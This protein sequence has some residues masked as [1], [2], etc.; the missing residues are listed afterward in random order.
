ML[1]R[2]DVF[3]NLCR[4]AVCRFS[5][6]THEGMMKV[7]AIAFEVV[8]AF[9]GLGLLI[10]GSL[11]ISLGGSFYYA[12]VGLAY[13]LASLLA[14]RG[15]RAGGILVAIVALLTIPWALWEAGADFWALFARLLSPIALAGFA[16]LFA[17]SLSA[18]ANR[19]LHYSGAV[20]AAVLF[21]SGMAFGF[22]PHGVIRPSADITP[23][24]QAKGDNTPSD[25]TSYG[26]T[27]AGLRYSPFDQINRGNV[28]KLDLAWTYRTG[29]GVGID[30]NT[31][32]QIGNTVYSCTPTNVIT[33]IDADTGK[34]RWTSDPKASAPIWQRCRGVGYY[35]VPQAAQTA[36]GICNE[37]LVQ[38][39]IDARIIELDVKTGAACPGFGN[40]GTVLL[41]QNMGEVK[42]GFYFQ[43]SAPLIARNLIIV[44]GWVADNQEVGEPSGVIRAF[45]V[46]TGELEWAWDLGNPAIT[47]MP[48]DGETYTRGTPNMWTTAAF[49]DRLGLI[50]AP[51]GNTTPDYYGANRPPF[52]DEYNSSIVALDVTTGR[53]RWKFQTVHHDIWDYDLP[54]QPALIDLPDGKGGKLPAIFQT[55]K[56]GQ[57]FLLNRE[58]GVPL[59]KVE[60][61]PV[62]QTGGV[63]EEKLSPTQPYSVGMPTIGAD[64][65]TEQR[66]WGLTMFDQLAC[67]VAFRKLHY[68]GDFTPIGLQKAIEQPGNLGGFNWGSV[69][70]DVPNNLVF[71]NDIRVPT[72]FSLVPRD[73]YANL[74]GNSPVD[75]SGHSLSDQRG[76]PYGLATGRWSSVLGIPCAQP[77]FGTITAIDLNTRKIAWQIPAGTAEQLGPSG[78]KTKLAMPMGMPTY[79]GTSA[80]AG[81]VVFFAGFRD[82]YIRAYDAENGKELWKY[83][84]PVGSSATPMTYVS[85]A[86]GKQYVLI[87]VGGAA[88]SDDVGDYVMAFALGDGG[89]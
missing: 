81:G 45:N 32:L 36:D 21:A 4:G 43:T 5:T 44:G 13:L 60:E 39:T 83:P 74:I 24:N 69:S 18:T 35:K 65:L 33:A 38:T 52:S 26:R 86:T 73:L 10:G 47:K 1:E 64:L 9:I 8:L 6:P 49:D 82:Y 41:S 57:L 85:P 14:L 12:V 17:P 80:T 34:A 63:P 2:F 22:V 76:T 27:T 68:E 37:R 3:C 84:L 19:K 40:N 55:T 62:P 20:L 58:T 15:H 31:P 56:R 71:M 30:Q 53:E 25:W 48:P 75:A 77:P 46:I 59:T 66:M 42:T 50:Y 72:V 23:Y 16:L 51:L 89:K 54:A 70:V 61:R 79:A 67:R 87:S 28:A 29:R 7:L 88:Y 78:I 11:L